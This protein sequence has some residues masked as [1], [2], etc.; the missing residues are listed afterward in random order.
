MVDVY[1]RLFHAPLDPVPDCSGVT[2]H[3][4]EFGVDLA[5]L[6]PGYR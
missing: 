3:G 2:F 5:A 4:R 6:D 1:L